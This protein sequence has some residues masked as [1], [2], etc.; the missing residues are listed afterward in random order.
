MTT[1]LIGVVFGLI[2]AYKMNPKTIM[3]DQTTKTPAAPKED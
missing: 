2:L 3:V 1:M